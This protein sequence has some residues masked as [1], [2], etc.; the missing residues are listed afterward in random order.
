[1]SIKN[2]WQVHQCFGSTTVGPRGQAVIPS[3][4]RKELGIKTGD[5]FLVFKIF[6]GHGLALVKTDAIEQLLRLMSERLADFGKTLE[7]CRSP[8]TEKPKRRQVR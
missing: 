8:R 3:N 2:I 7:D 5:T 4:A 6:Q 1:M